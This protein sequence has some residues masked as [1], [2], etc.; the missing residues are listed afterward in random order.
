M[1]DIEFIK[2]KH[3]LSGWSIREIA[4]RLGYSRQTVR[5]ALIVPAEEPQYRLDRVRPSPVMDKHLPIIE[6]W[7]KEDETAPPKQRHTAKRIYDR[8][9][10]EYGFTGAEST[11]RRSVAK[12]RGLRYR[13]VFVPLE[14]VPGKVAQADF[15][16]A[17]VTIAGSRRPATLFCMRAKYSK[18][19]FVIAYP[20]EKIEA[21]LA[22]HVAAF[23]F[24]GGVFH[25]VW[26]DNPK[27]A[28]TKILAGTERVENERLSALRAHYLF[29][30]AFCTPSSPHEKGSVENLVGY[31]RRNALVP[32]SRSFA[33]FDELNE[34]L[35]RWC[36]RE[37]TR[38]S[39][40][41]DLEQS[42]LRSLPDHSF[43]AATHRPVVVSKTSLVT[44]DHVRYSVP[45]R[46]TGRTLSCEAYVDSIELFDGMTRVASHRRS[47]MR[48]DSRF[49]LVHYLPAFARKPRAAAGCA[50]LAQADPVFLAARDELLA[51]PGGHKVFA[52]ILL[53][54]Q[55]FGMTTLTAA[56]KKALLSYGTLSA[57]VIRQLCLN[58][59]HTIPEPASVP[60][61]LSYL[62]PAPDLSCYNELVDRT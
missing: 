58:A 61:S 40:P 43:K 49:E 2:K 38:L 39:N 55:E 33:S 31:V 42:A 57:V 24:F 48:G 22:G 60:E 12:L 19:P 7:L 8:L 50:A 16:G 4:R 11:V 15:G 9:V 44:I 41:W 13:E 35:K 47:Y 45:V 53:L 30:S 1:V 56:L 20:T 29:D 21:F 3:Q 54:G 32:A 23:S 37:Q 28:V 52:E 34:H 18:A 27:T 5:K 62:L 6:E 59:C 14:S 51:G 26:Y 25:E 17:V 10:D 36:E 46:Y